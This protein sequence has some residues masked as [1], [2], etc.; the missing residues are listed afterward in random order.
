MTSSVQQWRRVN[1]S[2][3]G[4]TEAVY[5][6]TA[7]LV[8]ASGCAGLRKPKVVPDSVTTCRQLSC[9]GV[10][11]MQ[12]G[13]LEE[14][15]QLLTQAVSMSPGDIDA[16]RQL[17]EALWQS[18]ELQQAVV[19]M[20]AAVRLD[21]RHAPTVVRSGE[22]LLGLGDVDRALARGEEAILLDSTL[23]GAWALRGRVYRRRGD[24]ERSL[25]DVH[26]ALRYSPND[27]ALLLEAA[28][29]QYQ[30]DR[31]H[32]CLTTLQHLLST[33]PPDQQ[34]QQALWLEGLAYGK[35]NRHD[36]AAASLYAAS[37]KGPAQPELLYQLAQ[38]Q[39]AAGRIQEAKAT[40]RQA[41][42]A[43]GRHEACQALLA[44]LEDAGAAGMESTLRR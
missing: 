22:M 17:A 27:A 40:A 39:E 24:F 9:E 6:L 44:R 11:A 38:A 20:E 10:A 37:L 36:E 5:V 41:I 16:R 18:G 30:L 26:Q 2:A 23:A 8:F 21:P 7:I 35:V 14:A 19:H 28:E 42:A 34:P 4:R 32:R 31:P 12:R 25:A 13:Q 1:R 43:G 3:A 33:M 15:R 29:M